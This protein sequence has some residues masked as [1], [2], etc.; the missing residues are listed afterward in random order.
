MPRYRHGF[1]AMRRINLELDQPAH[2]LER[3]AK[4]YFA[5][6][7]VPNRLPSTGKAVPLTRR[8]SR[9]GPPA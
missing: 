5:R 2:R 8:K 1:L 7:S 4:Q 3:V 9:A 6:S